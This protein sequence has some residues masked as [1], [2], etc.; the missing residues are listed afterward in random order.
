MISVIITCYN[1]GKYLPICIESVI[2]QTYNDIEIIIVN[3]GSI[4]DTEAVVMPYLDNN[5][6]KYIYQDNQGQ[7]R[8][9]NVG[10]ANSKGDY[11]AFLDAD[12]L[13]HPDKLAKQ[14]NCFK[15]S[16]VG[17]VFSRSRYIDEDGHAL[18]HD[19]TSR[20]LQPRRG[21]VTDWLFIDNFVQ[22]SSS[23]VKKEC[24]D[25]LGTFD[26]SLNMGIDW[27]L[28]LRISTKYEF[29]YVDERLLFYR[30]GHSGQMSKNLLERHRCSDRIMNKFLDKYGDLVPRDII[31]TA[32]AYTYCNRGE[33]Y[34]QIDRWKSTLFFLKSLR[35]NSNFMAYKGILKNIICW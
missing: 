31:N 33:Y 26:E 15:N 30:M 5:K 1:Y 2:E 9:K 20:Y 7:A 27:D 4:D 11:I 3:D 16:N 23:V 22:F 13:W 12:D 34:R 8:A 28:W 24:F 17:V 6:F 21:L 19:L 10:I 35:A 14:I 18:N 32:M 29:D 25:N